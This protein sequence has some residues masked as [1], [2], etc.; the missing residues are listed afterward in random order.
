MPASQA[1]ATIFSPRSDS[2]TGGIAYFSPW[3]NNCTSE[4]SKH[5][6]NK[7][8]APITELPF[9]SLY[10]ESARNINP[11]GTIIYPNYQ[12]LCVGLACV[13]QYCLRVPVQSMENRGP[14]AIKKALCH[15]KG[16]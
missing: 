14:I 6:P 10:V 1:D 5:R 11:Q 13:P 12:V 4:V 8:F 15:R 7:G 3:I 16:C 9:F 2:E